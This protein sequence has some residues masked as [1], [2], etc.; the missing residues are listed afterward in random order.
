MNLHQLHIFYVV[1]QRQ[2]VTKAAAELLLSQ[3]AVSLQ[4]KALEKELGIPLFER[5]GSRLRL[6][7]AGEV[8]FRC[9]SSIIH[10]KEEAVRTIEG[11]CHGVRGKLVLGANTTGGMYLLPRIIHAFK[12]RYPEAEVLLHIDS[13]VQI[14]DKILQN[15]VDLGLVGGPTEHRRLAS[16]PICQDELVLIAHPSH[17][18]AGLEKVPL[19]ELSAHRVIVPDQGSRTR[20]FVERRLR[21]EGIALRVAMQLP[22]TEAVKKAV[23]AG[24]G[25]AFVSEGAVERERSLGILKAIPLEDLKLTRYMELV[26]RKSKIFSPLAERFREVA[27]AYARDHLMRPDTILRVAAGVSGSRQTGVPAAVNALASSSRRAARSS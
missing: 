21:E 5:A 1:A 19:G 14:Y 10:T 13:T 8:L 27:H 9:A 7:Q 4:V 3:P 6:T 23:E 17:P 12:A 16:E 25:I 18:L 2:S 20:L 11:L 24:L 26:Y 15:V 22:G